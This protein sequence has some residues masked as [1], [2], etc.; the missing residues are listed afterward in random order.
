MSLFHRKNP[1]KSPGIK[2]ENIDTWTC[3]MCGN[4]FPITTKPHLIYEGNDDIPVNVICNSCDQ[5]G[6]EGP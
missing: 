2:N 4:E 5:L 3:G 1:F 6:D